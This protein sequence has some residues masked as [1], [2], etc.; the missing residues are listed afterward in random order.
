ML[1][2]AIDIKS[3]PASSPS[4]KNSTAPKTGTF[5]LERVTGLLPGI[6]LATLIA[7]VSLFIEARYGGPVMLYALVI[8][9]LFNPVATK[10]SLKSGLSFSANTILKFGVALLAVKITVVDIVHLGFQTAVLVVVGVTATLIIG[11]VIGRFLSLSRDYSLICA[12]S[13][14]IC[15]SAAALAMTSVL[16]ENKDKECNTIVTI[17]A[18]TTLSTIAMVLYPLIATFLNLSDTQSGIFMG[19]TI[20]NVAQVV[21]AGYVVSDPAG[22]IATIVKLMRVACLVPALVIISLMYRGK[23]APQSGM[24]KP[25]FLPFFIVAFIA[26]MLINSTGIIPPGAGSVLSNLSRWA[27]VIAITALG[28]KTSFREIVG[29]GYKP[30]LVLSVQTLFL[31]FF[32]LIV[33]GFVLTI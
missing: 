1:P 22:E 14:A 2:E 17:I 23:G 27:L 12:G 19:I 3:L 13:V 6:L 15:G 7:V 16:P 26:I 8:G 11:Q 29:V 5:R 28:V 31:A 10:P 32:A 4:N 18:V 21:G 30:V 20:H 25:P 33:I 24:K 9:I